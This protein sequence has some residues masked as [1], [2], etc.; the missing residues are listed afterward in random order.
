ME[1][2]NLPT[3]LSVTEALELA[4]RLEVLQRGLSPARFE[5]AVRLAA[6][7]HRLGQMDRGG[8]ALMTELPPRESR[9]P[10]LRGILARSH[11]TAADGREVIE[12]RW[13]KALSAI[14]LVAAGPVPGVLADAPLWPVEIHA[15]VERKDVAAIVAALTA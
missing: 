10:D 1:K 9:D 14:P 2:H 5:E 6:F 7:L 8:L 11:G 12:V 15:L 4:D 3:R 13:G